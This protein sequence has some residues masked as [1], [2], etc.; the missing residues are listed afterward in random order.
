MASGAL[1]ALFGATGGRVLLALSLLREASFAELSRVAGA[2]P[3]L[4]RRKVDDWE[5]QGL[6]QT[7]ALGTARLTSFNPRFPGHSELMMLLEALEKT[8][9]QIADRAL[10]IR[11]RPRRRGKEIGLLGPDQEGSP[12]S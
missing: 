10:T 2:D 8:E 11:R 4:V 6:V 5:L 12:W 9:P 7:R 3:S 1:T